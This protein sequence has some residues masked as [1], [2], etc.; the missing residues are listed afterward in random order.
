MDFGRGMYAIRTDTYLTN[1]LEEEIK[2][3]KGGLRYILE[4]GWI[5]KR[6]GNIEDGVCFNGALVA[7]MTDCLGKDFTS[8]Y[9]HSEVSKFIEPRIAP[10]NTIP[11]WND[12]EERTEAEVIALYRAVIEFLEGKLGIEHESIATQ[13]E[14]VEV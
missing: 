6:G 4:H 5:Q 11:N 12:A 10:Y 1:T 8:R 13:K 7:T 14:L 9:Q 2:F 3:F